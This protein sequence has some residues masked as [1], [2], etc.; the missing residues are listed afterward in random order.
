MVG[1]M[2]KISF[3][4]VF[5]YFI[6]L[7]FV[8][9][10]SET[11][12][13]PV[14]PVPEIPSITIPSTENTRLVFTSDGG[15]DTLAFIATTGWSVAIKTADLAGDWLAVSP[16]TG[17]K[18]DNELIITLASNPSAEDREGEVIIQCGEVADTVI[19]RQN[20]NY[21]ATLSKDG[22]VRTWQEHTKGWGINLVMMGDGFVEMDMGRGG[23]YEVMMQKAMDSYFSVEPMHSL[24]EYFDV[25][26]VT[27]VSV[28]DSIDGG[29][30]L[31][32]TFTGGTSIKGDN[33]KCKQY[34][35]KVPLLGNS[36]RN[37]PMIVVM[38]SPR[39]A[40]T[41]YMHSLG[42]SIAFCP[43]VDN[44]DERFAQI[45]HHEAVG[46][47]FGYLGDEYDDVYDGEIP[48]NVMAE[49]IEIADRYG[50]YSNID[51]TPDITKV[52]WNYFIS[53]KRYVNERLGA[54]EGAY[55]YRSGVWRPTNISIMLYNVGGFNAPCREAIYRRVM[56]L[57]GES[58]SRD[59]FLE[60]DAVNRKSALKRMNAGSVDRNHFIPL[61]SPVIID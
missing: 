31:G 13:L 9:A 1:K 21:L 27:V 20:F 39:Y 40:G 50:W 61:A 28:S 5:L 41:T 48:P 24:R 32:T 29:T 12:E 34:A 58:Y 60:Y 35:T 42:Y 52:K 51:F 26:S 6:T 19:V 33:E 43:Y 18:G 3:L 2:K 56:K 14:A 11:G 55:G 4:F 23:K 44:D 53:D 47:G 45:I 38:N 22:D 10:C 25:Y 7:L 57:A 49:L 17:N 8:V 37:T 46:H 36:V 15:E 30:A 16:L 59:K 54:W